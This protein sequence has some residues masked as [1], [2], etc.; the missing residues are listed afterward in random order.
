MSV[1]R[2]WRRAIG[3]QILLPVE[4]KLVDPYSGEIANLCFTN[5]RICTNLL[6][7]VLEKEKRQTTVLP[8]CAGDSLL[9]GEFNILSPVLPQV[10]LIKSENRSATKKNDQSFTL[11][12]KINPIAWPGRGRIDPNS[13]PIYPLQ[14][15]GK[16]K[17]L[18]HFR[19]LPELLR[20]TAVNEEALPWETLRKKGCEFF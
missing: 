13:W 14:V 12:A 3:Y 17:E 5:V 10:Q 20:L 1:L 16:R 7:R 18:Y 9:D 6:Y 2:F 11:L 19:I 4:S 15:L 8:D